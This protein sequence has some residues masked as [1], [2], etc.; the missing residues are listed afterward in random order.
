VIPENPDSFY[1]DHEAKMKEI[2]ARPTRKQIFGKVAESRVKGR[3]ALTK[4]NK[5]VLGKQ[6]LEKVNMYK[7]YTEEEIAEEK[8]LNE[9]EGFYNNMEELLNLPHQVVPFIHEGQ[10]AFRDYV[11]APVSCFYRFGL[12]DTSADIFVR[13]E[14]FSQGSQS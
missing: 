6:R 4:L 13:I 2:R 7:G 11:P 1:F 3:D 12:E 9:P 10:L 8:R 5:I 14:R